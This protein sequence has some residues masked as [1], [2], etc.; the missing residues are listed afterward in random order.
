MNPSWYE[1]LYL[2]V[3]LLPLEDSSEIPS[4]MFVVVYDDDGGY[5]Y[6]VNG[7]LIGRIWIEF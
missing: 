4:G 5:D 7:D 2:D 6:D 3:T 1:T